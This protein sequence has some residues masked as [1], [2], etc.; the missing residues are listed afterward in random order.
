[1]GRPSHERGIARRC[2]RA[3][4][5]VNAEAVEPSCRLR[6]SPREPLC[7]RA[8]H[9]RPYAAAPLRASRRVLGRGVGAAGISRRR[10]V[11]AGASTGLVDLNEGC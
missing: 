6:T 2:G 5:L 10:E 4:R 9:S 7:D 1:M 3:G 8:C 11:L